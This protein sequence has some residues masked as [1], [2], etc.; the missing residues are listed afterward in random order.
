MQPWPKVFV[1]RY[2][3]LVDDF[4]SLQKRECRDR[5]R[6]A[7]RWDIKSRAAGA[8]TLTCS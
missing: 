6:A 2:M 8:S 7:N 3:K 5:L 1:E 4:L